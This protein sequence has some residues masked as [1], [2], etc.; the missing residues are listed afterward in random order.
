MR[1]LITGYNGFTGRYLKK[2]L[3]AHGHTIIGLQSDLTESSKVADEIALVQ[4]EAV[5]H[6]AGVAFVGHGDA[7]AFYQV[8]LVGTRNLL[9]ALAEH[10][11]NIKSI[12][13]ASSANIYGNRSEG[14]LSEKSAPD[15]VNDYG[16]S[17]LAMEKMALL[18][19]DRLPLFFVRPF[20]YT[21][22]G[23][24]NDFLIPKIV[25]HFREK[26]PVIELGN[27]EIRRE[28]GDVRFVAEVYQQLLTLGPVGKT[29]NI[30]TGR[31]YS[32]KEVISI[33]EKITGHHIELKFNP[34]YVRANEVS[35][36]KGDNSYLKSTIGAVKYYDLVETL[37]WMLQD[38]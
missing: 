17:K 1:I 25:A 16:V 20:N 5:A 36:L 15:P 28:F 2:E 21:G 4:P 14:V 26:R 27:I 30:C 12:L 6:L 34:E 7:N 37:R 24:H 3:E 10:A 19:V 33:C 11:P 23:Q 18:W 13:L 8:N 35:V 31:A 22:I 32:I 9:V 38:N 29:F